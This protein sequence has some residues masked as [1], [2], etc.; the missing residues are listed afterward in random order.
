MNSKSIHK[1]VVENEIEEKTLSVFTLSSEN[2]LLDKIT[3]V[4]G[5]L[6]SLLVPDKNGVYE[7]VVLGFS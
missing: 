3:N 7:N 6:M 4:S 1:E 2:D 5:I